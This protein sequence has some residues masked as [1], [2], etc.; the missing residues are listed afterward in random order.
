MDPRLKGSLRVVRPSPLRDDLDCDDPVGAL[1][2]EPGVLR[3]NLRRGVFRGDLEPVKLA[4][5][6]DLVARLAAMTRAQKL[7]V[8]VHYRTNQP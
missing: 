7:H 3:D 2:P 1:E 6:I 4:M 8:T 5:P